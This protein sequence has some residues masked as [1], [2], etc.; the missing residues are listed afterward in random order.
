[1]NIAMT[2]LLILAVSLMLV[3][4]VKSSDEKSAGPSP[5]PSPGPGPSPQPP[6]PQIKEV[7]SVIPVAPV[8][9]NGNYT[10]SQAQADQVANAFG[11]TLA[12]KDLLD[13]AFKF[14]ADWCITGWVADAPSPYYPI[15]YSTQEG[16]GNGT[17]GVIA[18]LPPTRLAAVNVYGVKSGPGTVITVPGLPPMT[19]VPFSGS[20]KGPKKWNFYS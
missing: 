10:V 1:M 7:Y 8:P 20:N 17:T 11:G 6:G 4:V 5:S 9:P 19:A 13:Q 14:G 15:N 16:C 18:Y 12:S 3:A 2:L